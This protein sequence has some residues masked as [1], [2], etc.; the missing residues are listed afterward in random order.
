LFASFAGQSHLSSCQFVVI[1]GEMKSRSALQFVLVIGIAN[2][3]AD[4]TY[5]GA[6]GII[7]PF[8][9]SLGASAAIVGFVAGLGELIGYGLRSISGYFADKFHRHWVFAFLGYAVNM[10]AVPALAL[11]GR[12]PVAASLVVAE[13]SGRGIRKPTVEAMLSYAGKSI[14]AGWVFGLN[15]ALDQAGATVG[16]LLM[17]LVLYFKGGFRTGFGVLL[18]PALFCLA[19]LVVARLLHPRPHELE[20]GAGYTFAT[21]NFTRAYWIYLAAGGLIAAGFADFALIGFHFHKTNTVAGDLIPVFYAIAM[22]SSAVASIPLGRLFDRFGANISIFAFLI[23]AVAAPLIFLG[24][25][26]SALI[27]MIFWGVGMSAQGSLLQA[28]LAGVIP[29]QKRSTAFGLF[30]T[31]YGIAWFAGSALMGLLYD[32]SVL[33]VALFSVVLQLAAVP[34]LFFANKQR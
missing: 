13:R 30:D 19:I 26:V 9:G 31:G 8:L 22:A 15:E 29:P 24:A 7:G 2:F 18:V 20:E 33:A 3:F 10:L 27:G 34:V 23:S 6:R 28:M 17:A 5:E 32:K 12:W 1:R 25:T 11:A 16:P 14:G 21:T 4:F